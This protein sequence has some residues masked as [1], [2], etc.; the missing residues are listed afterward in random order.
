MVVSNDT[1][2]NIYRVLSQ[3]CS[4]K[5]IRSILEDLAEVPG[6]QSFRDTVN[7]L[8]YIHDRKSAGELK[9]PTVQRDERDESK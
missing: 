2:M 3:N 6:N 9:E 7:R 4:A 8:R 1:A 5:Q